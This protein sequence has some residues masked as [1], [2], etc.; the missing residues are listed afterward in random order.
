[1]V[2][3]ASIVPMGPTMELAVAC[4]MSS[5]MGSNNILLRSLTGSRRDYVKERMVLFLFARKKILKLVIISIGKDR[6]VSI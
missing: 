4:G 1:M 3:G 5:D 2:F 6:F